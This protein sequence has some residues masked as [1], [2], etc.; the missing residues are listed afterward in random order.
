MKENERTRILAWTRSFARP[1]RPTTGAW[2][3]LVQKTVEV[4]QLQ[5]RCLPAQFIDGCGR[6]CA[7]AGT[8]FAVFGQ[9]RSHARCVQRQMPGGS[10]VVKYVQTWSMP[11]VMQ[12]Q[13]LVM[14]VSVT[15][16]RRFSRTLEVPQIQLIA[17]FRWVR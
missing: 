9:G 10:D 15:M 5:C 13:V 6:P 12:V 17:W 2:G 16:Q 8:C 11:P 14:D 4:P 7:H 1:F 3:F